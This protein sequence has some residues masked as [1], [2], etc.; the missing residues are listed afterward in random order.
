MTAAPLAGMRRVLAVVAHPD[1]ESFGLGGVLDHLVR[2]GAEA[3]VLCFTH[4]EASTLHGRP[5][6]L[7]VVRAAELQAA[8][9]ALAL[10]HTRLLDYPDGG[11]AGIA[12]TELAAKVQDFAAEVHSTHLV[13]FDRGGITGHPDHVQ[14]TEAALAAAAVLD[15][16]V[17]G[18]AV[19]HA[20]TQVLNAELG[21]AFVGRY[22]HELDWTVRVDRTRQWAAIAAHASQSTGNPVLRRRLQLSG[23]TEHLRML[24][25]R[26]AVATP[27][28]TTSSMPWT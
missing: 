13:A 28:G 12:V 14:A 3:S 19:P 21:T 2:G 7:A 4:G 16:P 17:I 25:G 18:W 6:E 22:D 26:A 11:L 15:L 10:A 27:P 5:G 9:G 20:V 8:A 23:D 1:D 24:R